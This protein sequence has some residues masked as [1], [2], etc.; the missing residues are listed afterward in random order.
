MGRD[1]PSV[2]SS[3]LAGVVVAGGV[4]DAA[5]LVPLGVALG[6]TCVAGALLHAAPM[7]ERA[8]SPPPA[9]GGGVARVGRVERGALAIGM[10]AGAVAA[11]AVRAISIQT[12]AA[13]GAGLMLVASVL[14]ADLWLRGARARPLAIGV[15]R[16]LVYLTAGG[17][18]SAHAPG[19]LWAAAA[20]IGCY[21]GGAALAAE[22]KH[23]TP[24]RR[25][26]GIVLL[27][28]PLA[29]G[30]LLVHDVAGA[31]FYGL[32]LA[33]VLFT[34]VDAV[35]RRRASL[36]RYLAGASL[37]DAL[38]IAGQGAPKIAVAAA[39]GFVLSLALSGAIASALGQRRR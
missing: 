12:P 14:A 39:C 20:A 25:A 15:G 30:P 13:L 38:V 32:L 37:F 11:L 16:A 26:S 3:A 28:V 4:L 1:L 18:V 36:A 19:A 6:L 7:S 8:G 27:T 2:A 24:A 22:K 29:Y 5:V 23:R 31:I 34:S 33:W 21:A 35:L 10:L 17:A 9:G